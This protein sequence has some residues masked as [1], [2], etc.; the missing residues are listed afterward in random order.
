MYIYI[1]MAVSR[2]FRGQQVSKH[3]PHL[4]WDLWPVLGWGQQQQLTRISAGM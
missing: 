4:W 1:Y 3:G 2:L